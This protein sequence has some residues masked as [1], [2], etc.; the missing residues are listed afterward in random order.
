MAWNMYTNYN[1]LGYII[2]SCDFTIL[3]WKHTYNV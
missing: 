1:T 2:I 3:F